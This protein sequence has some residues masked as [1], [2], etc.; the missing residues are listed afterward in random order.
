MVELVEQRRV[1]SPKGLFAYGQADPVEC[2]QL[3]GRAPRRP[4]LEHKLKR[5]IIEAKNGAAAFGLLRLEL[6]RERARDQAVYAK[7]REILEMDELL[8]SVRAQV[9]EQLAERDRL[10]AE[11][12]EREAQ[13][14]LA[15]DGHHDA[16]VALL[17][18]AGEQA[19]ER[20]ADELG[21]LEDAE[22][23]P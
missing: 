13:L 14:A 16:L 9:E 3:G 4:K 17:R 10:D 1:G 12:A 19:V 5:R 21:W 2:G 20:A 22:A 11:L 23:A 6:E 18:A 15:R 8:F 7:D